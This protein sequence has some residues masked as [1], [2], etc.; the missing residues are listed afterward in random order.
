MSIVTGK[1]PVSL[2]HRTRQGLAF[3]RLALLFV[4]LCALL[5]AG[6]FLARPGASGMM[7]SRRRIRS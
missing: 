7:D 6:G 1:P 3:F 4:I 5:L 2:P